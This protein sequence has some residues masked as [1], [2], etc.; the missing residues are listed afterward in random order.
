MY[1][2][3]LLCAVIIASGASLTTAKTDTSLFAKPSTSPKTLLLTAGAGTLTGAATFYGLGALFELLEIKHGS[4]FRFGPVQFF[5]GIQRAFKTPANYV[6]GTAAL[7]LGALAAW[8][9]YR[10]QPEGKFGR[11][12]STLMETLNN[13]ILNELIA[14]EQELLKNIEESYI[15]YAYP[16][17][18]AY[19][20]FI[21]YHKKLTDAVKLMQEATAATEDAEFAELAQLCVGRMQQYIESIKECISIIRSSP[22]WIEQLKGNDTMLAREAQERAAIATQQIAFNGLMGQNHYHYTV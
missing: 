7:S 2:K 11:A 16:R 19:N 4:L 18:A 17:V 10:C 20:E 9:T 8:L 15:Y 5:A 6:I 14:A 13:E 12:H 22:D 21:N 3:N 1:K